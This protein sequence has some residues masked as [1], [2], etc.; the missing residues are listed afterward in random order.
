MPANTLYDRLFPGRFIKSKKIDFLVCVPS[1]IDVMKNSSDL[2]KNNLRSL[3]SIF[4]CGEALLKSQVENIFK[5]KK[6]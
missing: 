5:V 4:F 1:L 6:T 2:T 3:K